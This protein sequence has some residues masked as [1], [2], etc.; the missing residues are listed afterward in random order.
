MRHDFAMTGEITLGEGCSRI[1]GLK[2][3]VLAAH[4]GLVNRVIIPEENMKDIE[5]IPKR[6]LKKVELI[7]V[8]H[9]D[10]C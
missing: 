6:I 7:P 8:A 4:R 5:E 2:E 10:V 9:M 1:G 3:K